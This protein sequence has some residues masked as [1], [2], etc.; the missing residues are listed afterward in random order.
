MPMKTVKIR[1]DFLMIEGGFPWMVL[2]DCNHL[3]FLL[4]GKWGREGNLIVFR[5]FSP[6]YVFLIYGVFFNKA[7]QDCIINLIVLDGECKT[8]FPHNLLGHLPMCTSDIEC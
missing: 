6:L 1:S 3:L 7:L 4:G 8:I 2:E 5:Y